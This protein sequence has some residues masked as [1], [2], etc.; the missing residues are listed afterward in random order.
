MISPSD[1]EA[2]KKE[3]DELLYVKKLKA[4]SDYI[5]RKLING[6]R[7]IKIDKHHGI[8][9]ISNGH[10]EYPYTYDVVIEVWEEL[11]KV[12]VGAGWNPIMKSY[13]YH[14]WF[15]GSSVYLEITF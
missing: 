14:H 15:W 3:K 12:L 13:E 11:Y 6:E 10:D 5:E 4:A 2:A 9:T 1:A 8:L 7:K